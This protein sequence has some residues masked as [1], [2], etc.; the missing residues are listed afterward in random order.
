MNAKWRSPKE[1]GSD[2][3]DWWD[4]E[5]VQPHDRPAVTS[6]DADVPVSI[7]FDAALPWVVFVG[8]MVVGQLLTTMLARSLQQPWSSVVTV[9]GY[10]IALLPLALWLHLRRRRG[11]SG[12]PVHDERQ[13]R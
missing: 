13:A 7:A 11:H 12:G 9:V 1:H 6:S 8:I 10:T 3:E 5:P 2:F 4:D